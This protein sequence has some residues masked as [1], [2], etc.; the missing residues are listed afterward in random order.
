MRRLMLLKLTPTYIL[1]TYLTRDKYIICICFLLL[2]CLRTSNLWI[3]IRTF[4]LGYLLLF[5][6]VGRWCLV[7]FFFDVVFQPIVV[8]YFGVYVRL[9][10][11]G[12]IISN[13]IL[14]CLCLL[15]LPL[16]PIIIRNIL[17]LIL[18]INILSIRTYINHLPP[19]K[20]SYTPFKPSYTTQIDPWY[21]IVVHI[22]ILALHIIS[23]I[24]SIHR[25]GWISPLVCRL[26]IIIQ[27]VLTHILGIGAPYFFLIV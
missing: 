27:R 6:F 20:P 8:V 26:L 19:F 25:L 11:S 22:H 4:K 14:G 17:E 3:F 7:E 23:W 12:V 21:P 5:S 1:S 9:I 15:W 13:L 18:H 24:L 2:F 10:I 16:L